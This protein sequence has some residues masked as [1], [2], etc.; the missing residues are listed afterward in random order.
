MPPRAPCLERNRCPQP[1]TAAPVT[2]VSG[3]VSLS[4][5]YSRKSLVITPGR[6]FSIRISAPCSL[7]TLIGADLLNLDYFRHRR[8]GRLDRRRR[9]VRRRISCRRNRGADPE[10]LAQRLG[11]P[12]GSLAASAAHDYN[13]VCLVDAANHFGDCGLARSKRRL[14]LQGCHACDLAIRFRTNDAW[15]SVRWATPLP[16]YAAAT[17]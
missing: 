10:P 15:G 3:R 7:G 4:V 17:A 13:G 6:M 2:E 1:R 9:Q 8:S 14:G 16:A 11:T 12:S 5:A